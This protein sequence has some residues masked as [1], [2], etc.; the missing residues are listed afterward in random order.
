MKNTFTKLIIAF[1]LIPF[2]ELYLLMAIAEKTSFLTT[3]SI[4]LFTG[5]LGAYFARREGRTVITQIKESLSRGSM[6]ANELMHGLCIL[7]G[8]VLLITPGIMTD[9]LGFSLLLSISRNGY[10]ELIKAYMSKKFLAKSSII[11]VSH[12]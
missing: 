2:M 7:I 12:H 6:P 11:N 5:V 3:V 4:V 1:T 9:V 10:V 8:S